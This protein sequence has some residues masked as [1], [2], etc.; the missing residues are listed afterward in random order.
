MGPRDGGLKLQ[1]QSVSEQPAE[2]AVYRSGQVGHGIGAGAHAPRDRQAVLFIADVPMPAG[3]PDIEL[4]LVGGL[5]MIGRHG[6]LLDDRGHGTSQEF[7]SRT[8]VFRFADKGQIR[9]LP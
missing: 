8:R 7:L 4:G 5:F 2:A 9:I 1:R 6:L 3:R